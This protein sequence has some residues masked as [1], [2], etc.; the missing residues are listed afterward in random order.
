M[1]LPRDDHALCTRGDSSVIIF[2]GFVNGARVNE[3]YE[4]KNIGH[5]APTWEKHTFSQG[6]GDNYPVAR[7]SHSISVH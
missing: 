5:G 3:L 1:P 6:K 7:A 2:G 4:L